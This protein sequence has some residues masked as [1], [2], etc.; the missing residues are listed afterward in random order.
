M[1]KGGGGEVALAQQTV[2]AALD[3]QPSTSRY[4]PAPARMSSSAT[5]IGSAYSGAPSTPA[6]ISGRAESMHSVTPA[7]MRSAKGRS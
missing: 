3:T 4:T 7:A 2:E 1:F 6:T 5:S